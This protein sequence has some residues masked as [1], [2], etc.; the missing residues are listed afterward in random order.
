MERMRGGAV[1]FMVTLLG[2]PWGNGK[3]VGR[4][5]ELGGGGVS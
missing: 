4:V 3:V 2:L 5:V 1:R